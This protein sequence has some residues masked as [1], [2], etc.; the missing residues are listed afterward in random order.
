[1]NIWLIVI[2]IMLVL[3]AA[4]IYNIYLINVNSNKYYKMLLEQH[5]SQKSAAKS[6]TK[7]TT[8]S[9]AKT[10]GK[11]TAKISTKISTNGGK[12]VT[13]NEFEDSIKL[14]AAPGINIKN[15]SKHIKTNE[16]SDK[17]VHLTYL[18]N[19]D[20]EELISKKD[21]IKEA[22]QLGGVKNTE[23]EW[24]KYLDMLETTT[25]HEFIN[26]HNLQIQNPRK[27]S[28]ILE[29]INKVI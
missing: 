4:I 29:D 28:E 12:I 21:K 26:A 15:I 8:K 10:G 16:K 1:M 6:T 9:T 2:F 7:S 27:I 25:I 17:H 23:D 22:F 13:K 24:N 20:P 11:T 19:H 14:S 18:E 5:Q 3:V